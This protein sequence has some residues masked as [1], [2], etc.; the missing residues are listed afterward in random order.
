M[1]DA[2]KATALHFL[3]EQDRTSGGPPDELCA[4]GY[5]A[6]F[7]GFPPMDLQSPDIHFT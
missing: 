4:S 7:A 5:T 2:A 1:P 3:A 6:Y